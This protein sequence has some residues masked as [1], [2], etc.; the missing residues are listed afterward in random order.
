M[1]KIQKSIAIL[2]SLATA[3]A[4]SG[5]IYL[6]PAAQAAT[7]ADELQQQ[8]DQ[9]MVT[10]NSL[11]QQIAALQGESTTAIS[12]IPAGFTFTEFMKRGSKGDQ[13]KYLQTLLNAK[14]YNVG[15]ADGIFGSKTDAG[16]KSYQAAKGLTAD[17]LVGKNTRA[18]LNT[19]LA[20]STGGD[21]GGDTGDDTTVPPV[22]VA[23]DQLQISLASDT[24]AS[25]SVA[26]GGNANFSKL[27]LSAGSKDVSISKI[28]VTQGGQSATTDAENIK[29]VDQNG[30]NLGTTGSLDV[31]RRSLIS[32]SPALVVSANSS[33][34]VY[35]RA[36]IDS[37]ATAG[38]T[39]NFGIASA[40]D[41]TATS[42]VTLVSG[43][44]K[45]MS[46]LSLSIATVTVDKDGA[47]SDTAPDVGDKDV[48]ANRF[49]ASNNSVEPV[50]IQT[51][52]ALR[53]GTASI[54][55]VS[56]IELYSVT[57]SKTLSEASSWDATDKVA[58]TGLNIK[59]AKGD[60]YRFQIRVDITD[61]TGKTINADIIDG[62][63]VLVT[64]KGD[65]YG[66]YITPTD[67]ATW[68]GT[69]TGR[70]SSNQT[71]ASGS[72]TVT[73]SNDI[74]TGNIAQ[75]DDQKLA[76]FNL[77]VKGEPI[78]ITSFRVGFVGGTS[79]AAVDTDTEISNVRIYDATNNETHGPY[80]VSTTNVAGSSTTYGSSVTTTDLIIL[81]VGSH[82][83]TVSVKIASATS[84]S[85]TV[86]VGIPDVDG[87]FTIKGDTSGDSITAGA[88]DTDVNG[89]TQTVRAGTLSA[90]TLTSP[91]ARSIAAGAQD[92]MLLEA[93]LDAANSGEDVEVSTIVFEDT[94]S[95]SGD[96]T[97]WQ[98]LEVWADLD[99]SNSTRG[100]VYEAKVSNSTQPSASTGANADETVSVTI[101][102][103]VTVT[104]NAFVKVA[105]FGDLKSV[106]TAT[107]AHTWSIDT[108]SG[109]V[110]ATGKS[111]GSSVTLTPSG[112]GQAITVA[113]NGT[114]TVSVVTD[115]PVAS[116][117]IGGTKVV[118]GVTLG[119]FKLAETGKVE[120]LDLDSIKITDDGAGDAVQTYYFY[121]GEVLV[122]TQVGAATAEIFLND[123][124]VTIPAD[125]SVILTVKGDLKN[126]DG[127]T[128]QNGDAVEVTIAA[129]GDVDTTGLQSGQ[130]VDSTETSVDAATHKL[131][132]TSPT[133]AFA[134][135]WTSSDT[136]KT[137]NALANQEVARI[138][139]T[140]N[141][142]ERV[143]FGLNASTSIVIQAAATITDS[144]AD[145]ADWVLED[146]NGNSLAT[147]SN[148]VAAGASTV[149]LTF[150]F[151]TALHIEAGQTKTLILKADLGDFEA[152]GDSIQIWL[153][154]TAGDVAWAID[155]GSSAYNEGDKIFRGDPRGVAFVNPS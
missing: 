28:Y 97:D 59:L 132:E 27:T 111:T 95:S 65:T 106:A 42:S 137:L 67:G 79:N 127:T 129:A 64:V 21:T 126:V 117:L 87:S 147:A 141:S 44:G 81:P 84:N 33:K 139:V 26:T 136:A 105:L 93:S 73:K 41:V 10:I 109:D 94:E 91:A 82:K 122:G 29:V 50:T 57:E 99:S 134:S 14:G 55:D 62:T 23:G 46:I 51:I 66:Y 130:A 151:T 31:N 90:T 123:G 1:S 104:K 154:N 149:E 86:Y 40:S 125:K 63:D 102:P 148:N 116:I 15:T 89:N 124:I 17:G 8:I 118:G 9:L 110:T 19:D 92:V 131:Y 70:G 37:S 30:V 85:D 72:V 80:S 119:K 18:Q 121:I 48:I 114:L 68:T 38:R 113:A 155:N 56:N 112:A 39:V 61:G 78:R 43:T 47:T 5:A 146:Q 115:D 12:G 54:T 53:V 120:A 2:T 108:D 107:E 11:N 24:P 69:A 58:F 143:S 98:N 138:N 4:F 7:T 133:I 144:D 77:E 60:T 3:L 52:E 22:P 36:G 25:T 83:F 103:T 96:H 128:I 13:V 75:A 135:G 34:T 101:T 152:D 71:I 16:A 142:A 145:E 150:N 140:A 32:F 100:D 74:A 76:I 88:A 49:K 45:D 6:A 153:D 20:S 35:I